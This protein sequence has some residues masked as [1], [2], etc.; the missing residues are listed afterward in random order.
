MD[1]IQS[2]SFSQ[3]KG[4]QKIKGI[5]DF[6][7]ILR[8]RWMISLTLAL[9]IALGFAYKSLNV[10][11][12]FASSSSFRLI[13]PPAIINLQKVDRE[14]Q[15]QPLVAKH[16]DGLNSQELRAQVVTKIENNPE[17]KTEILSPYIQD[18]LNISVSGAISYSVSVSGEG[19]PRFTISSNARSAR[20]AMIIAR[21]VQTEYEILHK[22][23]ANLKV[24]SAKKTL[25]GLL[26]KELQ[27]EVLIKK[28][29][30]ELKKKK[31]APFLED[32]KKDNAT[33]KS[34]YQSEITRCNIEQLRLESIL[35]K[36]KFCK[37]TSRI[38]AKKPVQLKND[39][40]CF[41][42]ILKS[43]KLKITET[44]RN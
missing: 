18:G 24:E 33:R 7:L 29:M 32:I 30:S 21:E 25:E 14:Q 41:L 36:S 27:K 3:T 39:L 22:S 13:P 42:N 12:Y 16:Q 2:D 38:N 43:M 34:Q 5:S 26:E 44:F 37:L 11:E 9:P 10:P 35:H 23:R 40:S 20:A 17:L 31:N 28:K 4:N 6:I 15:L 19:R 8:D 1:D